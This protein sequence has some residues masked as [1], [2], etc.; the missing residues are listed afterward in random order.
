MVLVF[1]SARQKRVFLATSSVSVERL[2]RDQVEMHTATAF[3]AGHCRPAA[4]RLHAPVVASAAHVHA[5][6]SGVKA[7]ASAQV[8][9]Q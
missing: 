9:G 5:S 8:S 7:Q 6:S 2:S 3:K 4:P 1:P